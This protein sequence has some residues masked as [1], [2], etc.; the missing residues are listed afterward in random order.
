MDTEVEKV[1]G[2]GSIDFAHERYDLN[3]NAQ[4]KRPSIVALRGPIVVDGTFTSPRVHPAVGPVA[5]RVGASV[6][7]GVAL[8]P[9]AALL[10][11][12]DVGGNADADC[13]ALIQEA[14]DNVQT[15]AATAK[16]AAKTR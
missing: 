12:I 4:A 8:T 9:L 10:P 7:L 16:T 2:E 6:A 11:L 5:A 1:V 14:Q 3:L 15:R 13:G